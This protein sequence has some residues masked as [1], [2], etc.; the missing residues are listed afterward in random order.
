MVA[1]AAQLAVSASVLLAFS[2]LPVLALKDSGTNS[3][4]PF[5]SMAR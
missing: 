1:D 2:G 4:V 3:P 5:V